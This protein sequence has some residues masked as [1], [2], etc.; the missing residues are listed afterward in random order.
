MD[1]Q[2]HGDFT[3]EKGSE[4]ALYGIKLY[5]DKYVSNVINELKNAGIHVIPSPTCYRILH[6]S[7]Q[8][9]FRELL[10]QIPSLS[11][12]PIKQYTWWQKFTKIK[13]I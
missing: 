11:S 3:M 4:Q 12:Y 7:F 13:S 9:S 6:T 10:K 2:C 8:G 5:V 1:I